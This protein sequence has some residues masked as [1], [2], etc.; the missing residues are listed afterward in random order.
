MPASEQRLVRDGCVLHPRMQ[1][2]GEISIVIRL[3][4]ICKPGCLVRQLKF[5]R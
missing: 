3:K 1:G 4:Q 5:R 2:F